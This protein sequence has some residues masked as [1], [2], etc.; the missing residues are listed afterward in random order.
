[1]HIMAFNASPRK[2][3]NTATLLVHALEGARATGADV[4]LVHLYDFLFHG[5]VSCLACK[6]P[7]TDGRHCAMRD[8]LSPV[9]E[10][11]RQAEAIFIGTPVYLYGESASFRAFMERLLY[12][13]LSYEKERLTYFESV[14][15]VGLIYTMGLSAEQSWNPRPGYPEDLVLH[16]PKTSGYFF[17]RIFG[18]CECLYSYNTLQV[19]DYKAYAMSRFDP[20]DKA[21]AHREVFPEDCRK[22]RAFGADLTRQAVLLQAESRG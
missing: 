1:M 8:A 14:K 10:Q 9:L 18:H 19:D 6:R 20:A 15:P 12:P 2:D 11:A 13:L 5:C 3:R 21:R 7:H 17:K 16:C 4:E 22:A